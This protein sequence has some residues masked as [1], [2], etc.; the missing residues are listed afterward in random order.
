MHLKKK[1]VLDIDS[2]KLNQHF[3]FK[4]YNLFSNK[5][6]VWNKKYDFIFSGFFHVSRIVFDDSKS[7]GALSVGYTCGGLCG[8]GYIIFIKKQ[9]KNW[10]IDKIMDTWI[11]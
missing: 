4:H 10:K 7:F 6:E 9:G 3:K 8:Q 5:L 2:I 1:L 11:S